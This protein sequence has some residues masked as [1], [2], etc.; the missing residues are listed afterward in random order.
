[1]LATAIIGSRIETE[2]NDMPDIKIMTD[3]FMCKRP[4]QVG[5]HRYDG[6]NVPAW[7]VFICDGCRRA[8]W[9]GLVPET[10]PHLI[11]HLKSKGIDVKLNAKG[12][13]DIPQW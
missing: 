2:V 12:W 9:D 3:C 10:Y 7:N 11:E 1:M 6:R 13:L 4:V 8:N 5:P